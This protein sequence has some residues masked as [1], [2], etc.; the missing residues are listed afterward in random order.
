MTRAKRYSNHKGGRKYDKQTHQELAKS[1]DHKDM[2]EKRQASDIF[3]HVWVQCREHKGYLARKE[4]FLH[5][6]KAWDKEQS[7]ITK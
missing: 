4:A 2:E 1:S 5:E 7:D 6:Q 3:K